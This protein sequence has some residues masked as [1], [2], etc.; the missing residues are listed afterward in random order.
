MY[1]QQFRLSL[2]SACTS[3]SPEREPKKTKK[4]KRKKRASLED[5]GP[6][7]VNSYVFLVSCKVLR[8][9]LC[10]FACPICRKT[11]NFSF[12]SPH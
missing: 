6:Q 5:G 9:I 8:C 4:S 7:P 1:D 11:N 10:F 3:T 12:F 2:S